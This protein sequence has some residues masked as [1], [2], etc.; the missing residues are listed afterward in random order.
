MNMKKLT[1]A[2]AFIIVLSS[3]SMLMTSCGGGKNDQLIGTWECTTNYIYD[4]AVTITFKRNGQ[5]TAI[6]GDGFEES[7]RY[8]VKDDDTIVFGFIAEYNY[9]IE[10]DTLSLYNSGLRSDYK[11]V[12]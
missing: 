7:G 11:K 9:R 6:D 1:L 3:I 4:P 10:G 12:K 2:L 8:K 5:Y